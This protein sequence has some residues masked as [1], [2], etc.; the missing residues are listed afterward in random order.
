MKKK[1]ENKTAVKIKN[2]VARRKK[3]RVSEDLCVCHYRNLSPIKKR[4]KYVEWGIPFVSWRG[5]TKHNGHGG[6][7]N[8]LLGRGLVRKNYCLLRVLGSGRFQT[9]KM[10]AVLFLWQRYT[11]FRDEPLEKFLALSYF[12]YSLAPLK[13]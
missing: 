10:A 6:R 7:H 5:V 3:W 8:E 13:I 1:S 9:L 12:F 11:N 4:Q 2:S